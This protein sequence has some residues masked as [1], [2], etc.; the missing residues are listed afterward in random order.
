MIT[1]QADEQLENVACT[2]GNQDTQLT[3]FFKL[4][5]H[6]NPATCAIANQLL[7]QEVPTCFSWDKKLKTWKLRCIHAG[8]QERSGIKQD[9]YVGGALGRM[10]FVGPNGGDRFFLRLLLTVVRGPTSFQDVRTFDGAVYPTDHAACVSWGLLED[11]QEWKTC[12]REAATFQT[13]MQLQRL[14]AIIL[15]NCAPSD[16]KKLWEDFQHHIGDDLQHFMQRQ[17]WA[18]ADLDEERIYDYG[19]YLLQQLIEE[20][21]KTIADVH[22]NSYQQN[23]EQLQNENCLL[24]E[25][26]QLRLQQPDGIEG[27]FHAQLNEEQLAAFDQVYTSVTENQG[28]TFLYKAL[29]YKLHSEDHIVLCVASSGIAALL[30]PGGRTSHSRFKIPL[31]IHEK[32]TCSISK[33]SELGRLI[34]QTTLIIWDEVPMQRRYCA[35]AFDWTCQDICSKPDEPF[36]GITVVFGGDYRQILPVVPKGTPSNILHVSLKWSTLWQQFHQL[37]LTQN[38]QLQG[39]PEAE[40]FAH[41]LLEI[42]EGTNIPEAAN[43]AS[44]EFPR[45][46][47][48]Q[49]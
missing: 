45:E 43:E 37:K 46:M 29:C 41:W 8:Q 1:F 7:Y 15:L 21:G 42:G 40:N 6:T 2:Q 22:M 20:G 9:Q 36:G 44:I 25:Q 28:K 49:S 19:H 33:T 4:N 34:Q 12:L 18:P 47:L 14:F 30:L 27:T 11:D 38:M 13:G 39:D 32:S 23:W 48:V 35:E 16:P 5:Q 17:H 24:Q 10:Y 31:E 26:Y 3:G